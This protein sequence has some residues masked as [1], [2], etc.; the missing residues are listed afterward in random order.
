MNILKLSLTLLLALPLS[1]NAAP[2]P[3]TPFTDA[4]IDQMLAPIALY[5]DTV[6][7]HVLI[8]ATVPDDVAAAAGWIERHPDLRGQEAVD[9]VDRYD[10]DPSVKALVA[11]PEVIERMDED[12]D[13]TEDLGLA[14]LEQE[15][16]VMDRVQVLRDRAYDNG[17]LDGIEHVR[18]VRE[19]E[20]IYIEP[21]ATR[22]VYVPYYNPL[23]VYGHWWWA[24]YPPHCW[25]WWAGR[26]A[27]YYHHSAFF[28]G[29]RY[30]LGPSW[31]VGAF[32]WPHRQVVVT[33]PHR[34]YVPSPGYSGRSMRRDV[35][36][37]DTRRPRE[38]A[39]AWQRDPRSTRLAQG[40]RQVRR[41]WTDVRDGLVAR[42][43]DSRRHDG[44]SRNERSRGT[45]RVARAETTRRDDGVRRDTVR[46]APRGRSESRRQDER[47]RSHD[48]GF[49]ARP[50]PG[51]EVRAV[52]RAPQGGAARAPTPRV[53]SRGE[54]RG[55]SRGES[56]GSGGRSQGGG[57][58][59]GGRS[60]SR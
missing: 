15:A 53:E 32:N 33:R 18:V 58:G 22:V 39:G 29:V 7:S 5:P 17:S 31:Y 37:H 41:S 50:Q 2:R 40:Q 59:G 21:A 42:R 23:V 49:R 57:N 36:H 10:W 16:T 34:H 60:R 9:A 48:T 27:H 20:Y 28:W 6:L 43:E 8:A 3:A 24:S 44:T 11:F 45:E 55:E 52:E 51:R 4:E 38:G 13:W 47:T 1:A 12:R 56:R 30:H 54:P 14:F 26:P 46:A 35:V 19:R 25:T